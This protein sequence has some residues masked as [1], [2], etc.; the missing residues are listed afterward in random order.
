[1]LEKIRKALRLNNNE[2]DSEIED[3]IA[4]A[5]SDLLL[6]GIIDDEK[7]PLIAR[8]IEIY[9]KANFG[10]DNSDSD[11]Y[12][13]AYQKLKDHLAISEDYICTSKT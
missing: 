6:A 4:S 13:E 9:C 5:K 2:F 12:A 3:L 11:K 7:K 10:L 1:M 8:A